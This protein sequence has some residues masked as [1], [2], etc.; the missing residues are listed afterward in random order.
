M[1]TRRWLIA[2]AIAAGCLAGG[3]YL[4]ATARTDVVVMSRDIEVPRPLTRE[5]LD[6]RAVSAELAPADAAQRIDDVVG[7]VPRAPVLRGQIV[8]TRAVAS[9]LADFRSG[10]TLPSGLRAVAIPVTAVN[11]IGRA[12][13]PGSRVDV[14]AVP[15]LGRAPAG[16]GTELLSIAATVLDVR[17]ES[18]AAL[19][20]RDGKPTGIGAERIGSVVIAIPVADEVRFADRIVTSTFVLALVSGR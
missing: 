14:L 3:L 18:G 9:E 4:A 8:L 6:V 16:R 5:D 20:P 7:L 2:L 10:L 13:V 12:I 17:G 11:A 19:V 1:I 15:L